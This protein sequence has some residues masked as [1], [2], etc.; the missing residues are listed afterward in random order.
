MHSRISR[1]YEKFS[2][3]MAFIIWGGWAFYVNGDLGI[4]VRITSGLAQGTASLIITLIMVRAV[5]G[6]FYRLPNNPLRLV[7]PAVITVCITGSGLVLVH[8]F[9]GTPRIV[10]TIFP[11]LTVAFIFCVYTALKLHRATIIIKDH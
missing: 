10:P 2:A 1:R 9:V 5:A 7:L 3:I 11:A 4:E 6:I 8:T